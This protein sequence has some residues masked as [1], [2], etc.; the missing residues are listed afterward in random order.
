MPGCGTRGQRVQ[1]RV[2]L[3]AAS[4]VP[5][6][7]QGWSAARYVSLTTLPLPG[8]TVRTSNYTPG[9]WGAGGNDGWGL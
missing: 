3:T 1:A 5:R 9:R 4:D 8:T 7:D 2:Q 6:V